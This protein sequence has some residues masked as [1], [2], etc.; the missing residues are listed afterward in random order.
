MVSTHLIL[1]TSQLIH[2]PKMIALAHDVSNTICKPLVSSS[3]ALEWIISLSF[4][5][6]SLLNIS[7]WM[8]HRHLKV[9]I[10]KNWC[11]FITPPQP[12][13]PFV[14][15]V[16]EVVTTIFS[17]VQARYSGTFSIPNVFLSPTVNQS[18]TN[19]TDI[20]TLTSLEFI[21]P[22][23]GISSLPDLFGPT[24]VF[25]LDQCKLLSNWSFCFHP[26]RS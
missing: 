23:L 16:S 7:T 21:Y 19:L 9:S 11:F 15:L 14:F 25:S 6:K 12:S 17:V 18:T 1:Y 4:R 24:I 2:S 10:S 3:L 8:F 22:F 26:E 20:S 5:S 13:I